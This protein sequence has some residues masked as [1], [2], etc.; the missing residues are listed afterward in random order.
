MLAVGEIM[1]LGTIFARAWVHEKSSR[2]TA[3]HVSLAA[4]VRY[5]AA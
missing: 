2:D 3:R 4:E 1:W 5:V